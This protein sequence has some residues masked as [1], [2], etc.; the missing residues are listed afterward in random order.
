MEIISLSFDIEETEII[1]FEKRNG[2]SI[3]EEYRAFLLDNNVF[4]VEPSNFFLMHVS[5]I[6]TSD[7]PDDTLSYFLGFADDE[8]EPKKLDWALEIYKGRIPDNYLPI[9]Y[10]LGGNVICIG[11]NGDKKGKIYFWWH[12][13]EEGEDNL[14]CLADDF[15]SFINSFAE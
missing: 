11:L 2:I 9:G 6:N 12:E 1:E 4:F 14:L 5:N 3:P 10:D 7:R 15:T 8:N 13:G